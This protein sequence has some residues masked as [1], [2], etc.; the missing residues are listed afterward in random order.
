MSNTIKITPLDKTRYQVTRELTVKTS[1]G[2]FNIPRGFI[3]DGASIPRIF[4]PFIGHPFNGK[5]IKSALVHDYLYDA[6]FKIFET[7]EYNRAYKA[8]VQADKIFKELLKRENGKERS[9]VLF[10]AVRFYSFFRFRVKGWIKFK[11]P[12]LFSKKSSK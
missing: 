10:G 4:W 3:F 5:Y 12:T 6:V 11:L 8:A 7:G 2:I 9:N 1:Y